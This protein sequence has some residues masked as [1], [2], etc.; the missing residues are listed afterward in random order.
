MGTLINYY[1]IPL[2]YIQGNYYLG[3]I[4]SLFALL[5]V[6]SWIFPLFKIIVNHFLRNYP[7]LQEKYGNK[8]WCIIIG[9]NNSVLGAE[10]IKEIAK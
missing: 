9:A 10:F 2:N 4:F 5:W 8:T 1:L 3:K 6:I 7:N